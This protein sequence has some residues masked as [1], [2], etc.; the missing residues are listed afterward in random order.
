VAAQPAV[1]ATYPT[2]LWP[3]TVVVRVIDGD[4]LEVCLKRSIGFGWLVTAPRMR[5]RLARVNTPPARTELGRQATAC[6]QLLTLGDPPPLVTVETGGPYKYGGE[7]MAEVLLP[8]GRNLADVL[9]DAG[10]AEYWDGRG[11]R[12]G[13]AANTSKR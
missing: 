7:W 4:T 3:D 1:D 10:L 5:L 2:E 9:V 11:P 6:V 13:G 12:P 8:D